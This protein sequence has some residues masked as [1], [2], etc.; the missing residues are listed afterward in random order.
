MGPERQLARRATRVSDY[1]NW[2][3]AF[4]AVA[5]TEHLPTAAEQLGV[6]SSALSRT[7]RLLE[8]ELGAPLFVRLGR[9]IALNEEGRVML[10]AVRDAMRRVDDGYQLILPGAFRGR[11]VLSG[12]STHAWLLVP[13]LGRMHTEHPELSPALRTLADDLVAAALREGS[14]DVALVDRPKVEPDVVIEHLTKIDYGIYCGRGHP[15]YDACDASPEE[16]TRHPFV[17]PPVGVMDNWPP[18]VERIVGAQ[19]DLFSNGLALA[20]AGAFLALLP[21][22]VADAWTVDG[23]L[24]RLVYSPSPALD[25]YAA[26][27]RPVG[28][29]MLTSYVLDVLRSLVREREKSAGGG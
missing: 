5:E 12:R 6:S 9:R 19:V 7:V 13:A 1:W 15:L 8:E 11:V 25:L 3:P 2:L 28:E 16:V 29:H 23:R 14:L 21:A 18:D 4:R 17:G 26:Y 22:P 24:R 27:R 10:R 20:E